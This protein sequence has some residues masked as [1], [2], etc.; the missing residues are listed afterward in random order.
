MRVIGLTGGIGSGKSTISRRLEELGAAV[1]DVDKVAHGVYRRGQPSYDK[2]V[3]AFGQRIVG[4]DREIDRRALG[5][6]VFGS[7]DEMKKLTDVVWPATYRASRDAVAAERDGGTAVVVLEAAVLIEANWMDSADE[8]WVATTT[9][10]K[11]INRV[12]TRN[13]LTREQAQERI[14]SQLSNEERLRYADVVIINDGTIEELLQQVDARWA[15]LQAR[16]SAQSE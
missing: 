1:V 15:E 7:P 6:A 12:M 11:A 2:L 5:A 13:G 10:N 3:D 14:A 4:A 8:I 16:L 9:V